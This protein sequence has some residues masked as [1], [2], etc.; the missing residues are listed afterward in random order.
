MR[1]RHRHECAT[2][3]G[4]ASW[5]TTGD[6]CGEGGSACP[7]TAT[8]L[9]IPLGTLSGVAHISPSDVMLP[10]TSVPVA[11]ASVCSESSNSSSSSSSPSSSLESTGTPFPPCISKR[12]GGGDTGDAGAGNP[13][14]GGGGGVGG[15]Y[16]AAED[17]CEPMYSSGL[18][19]VISGRK[20]RRALFLYS[21][22]SSR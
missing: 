10:S 11:V 8:H 14:T 12:T 19:M 6:D 16:D 4:T 7:L 1:A 20:A 21:F 3:T 15:G 18:G 13:S 9:S 5:I 22:F 2:T 17:G